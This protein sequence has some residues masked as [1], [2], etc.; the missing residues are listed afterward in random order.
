M[1]EPTNSTPSAVPYVAP[2]VAFLALTA[3]EG[4]LPTR[5][6]GIDPLWY[7]VVYAI[8]VAIVAVL[9]WVCRSPWRDL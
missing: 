4:Y 8:K 5:G 6:G 9:A 7:P 2:M 3:A 1:P